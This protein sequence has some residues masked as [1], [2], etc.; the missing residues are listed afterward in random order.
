MPSTSFT[1]AARCSDLSIPHTLNPLAWKARRIDPKP[2]PTS[3]TVDPGRTCPAQKS[4]ARVLS[5]GCLT[6]ALPPTRP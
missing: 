5:L 3:R 2:A 6:V 4:A 1:Y